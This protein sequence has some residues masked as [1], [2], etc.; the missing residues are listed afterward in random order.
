MSGTPATSSFDSWI[1]KISVGLITAGVLGLWAM[2]G[3]VARLEELVSNW[4]AVYD[5]RFSSI[6]ASIT[7]AD[8][9]RKAIR[10]LLQDIR[11]NQRGAVK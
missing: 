5:R 11:A 7:R 4:T 10:E 1:L 2:N 6:E 3:S 8:D 9:D